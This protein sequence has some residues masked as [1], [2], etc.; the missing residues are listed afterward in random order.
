MVESNNVTLYELEKMRLAAIEDL[1]QAYW[2]LRGA[3]D[4]SDQMFSVKHWQGCLER[5]ADIHDEMERVKNE[6]E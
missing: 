5:L 6:A 1:K 3:T 4:P 2:R